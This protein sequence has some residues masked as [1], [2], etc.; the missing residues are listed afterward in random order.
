MGG[1]PFPSG[2]NLIFCLK[3]QQQRRA[4]GRHVTVKI[5]KKTL[6]INVLTYHSKLVVDAPAN[7]S[8]IRLPADGAATKNG[9][10]SKLINSK[11]SDLN[12]CSRLLA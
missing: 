12:G 7:P 2:R 6:W 1:S 10:E 3:R 11:T 4:F 8:I 9:L 5:E